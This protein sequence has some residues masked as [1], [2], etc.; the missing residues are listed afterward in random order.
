MSM[1]D[2]LAVLEDTE[3]QIWSTFDVAVDL[4]ISENSRLTLAKTTGEAFTAA[5]L[6]PFAY[7]GVYVPSAVDPDVEA[8][9]I[10]ARVAEFVP[11]S[12]PVTTIKLARDNQES[13]R[14]LIRTSRFEAVVVGPKLFKQYPRFARDVQRARTVTVVADSAAHLPRQT[15]PSVSNPR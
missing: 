10:L 1:C 11:A 5:W 4:A 8:E 2:V 13:L 12:L 6:S 3:A 14:R 15:D 9:R 7:G